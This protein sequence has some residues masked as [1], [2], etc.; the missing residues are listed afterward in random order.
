[1]YLSGSFGSGQIGTA[2]LAN[3]AVQSG[4]LASGAVSYLH[5]ASGAIV[6][7]VVTAGSVLGSIS[8]GAHD[9]RRHPSTST[10]RWWN[11]RLAAVWDVV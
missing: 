10:P 11:R 3:A 9:F 6:S 5:L 7:G 1:L 8:S 4:N 2:H